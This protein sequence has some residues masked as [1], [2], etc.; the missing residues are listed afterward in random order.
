M[1]KTNTIDELNL[2]NLRSNHSSQNSVSLLRGVLDCW[3]WGW[4]KTN[5]LDTWPISW[6]HEGY[7]WK[8]SFIWIGP[9][10]S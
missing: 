1:N 9:L 6:L 8:G 7:S 5:K 3:R 10:L 2:V 4:Y